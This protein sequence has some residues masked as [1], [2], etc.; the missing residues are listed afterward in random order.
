MKDFPFLSLMDL[1]NC[2][3][4]LREDLPNSLI[5]NGIQLFTSSGNSYFSFLSFF[6]NCAKSP[7]SQYSMM[8]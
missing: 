3:D 8:I 5:L 2:K 1:I 6:K 4:N 7:P